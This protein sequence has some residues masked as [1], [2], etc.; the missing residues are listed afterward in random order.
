MNQQIGTNVMGSERDEIEVTQEGLVRSL[1]AVE[2]SGNQPSGIQVIL[3]L[4]VLAALFQEDG[5][6][7]DQEDMN[8]GID[9]V[10]NSIMNI[11][12]SVFRVQNAFVGYVY[13]FERDAKSAHIHL[14]LMFDPE[15]KYEDAVSRI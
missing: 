15:F 14:Y 8:T 11:F 12:E 9:G 13:S 6:Q 1:I 4:A 7:R 10:A 5:Q 3:K 2:D